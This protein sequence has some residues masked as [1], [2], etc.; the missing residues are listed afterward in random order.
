MW[1]EGIWPRHRYLDIIECVGL[2]RRGEEEKRERSQVDSI[3]LLEVVSLV[4]DL[5]Y[6]FARMYYV[7]FLLS[8]SFKEVRVHT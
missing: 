7:W 5:R 1:C 6:P 3:L 8:T 4:L 2:E